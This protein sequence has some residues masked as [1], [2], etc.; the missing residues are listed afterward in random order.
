MF[1]LALS[2][3]GVFD[4]REIRRVLKPGGKF[5]VSMFCEDPSAT[6]ETLAKE[7]GRFWINVIAAAFGFI[8]TR[9]TGVR[10][11]TTTIEI[12]GRTLQVGKRRFARLERAV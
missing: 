1:D 9:L 4:A 7:W 10:D 11:E 6:F 8:D 2:A 5:A 12:D 3:E